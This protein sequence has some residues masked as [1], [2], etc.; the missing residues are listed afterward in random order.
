MK[1]VVIGGTG[2]IGSQVVKALTAAG[3]E[4]LPAAPDTG[5]DLITGKGLDQVLEGAD[6]VINVAEE[7]FDDR[8]QPR[9]EH[10]SG[11]P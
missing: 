11:S 8:G 6:V 2:L 3:H 9:P 7:N 5:V 4:A 1:L 10:D